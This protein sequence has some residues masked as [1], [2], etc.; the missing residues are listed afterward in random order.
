MYILVCTYPFSSMYVGKPAKKGTS[1]NKPCEYSLKL[2]Q[3][4]HM[5]QIIWKVR[6]FLPKFC[7]K[8]RTH[9]WIEKV[10]NCHILVRLIVPL[11]VDTLFLAKPFPSYSGKK[12]ISFRPERGPHFLKM[13]KKF[14]HCGEILD[15]F[16][17][18][19]LLFLTTVYTQVKTWE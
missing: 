12:K 11:L 6:H 15:L 16:W 1:N 17:G 7:S 3:I 4:T 19:N 13:I 2:K 5:I 9:I 14:Y 18:G 8:K 10:F